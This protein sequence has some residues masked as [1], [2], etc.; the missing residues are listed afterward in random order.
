MSNGDRPSGLIVKSDGKELVIK[1]EFAGEVIVQWAAI[2]EINSTDTLHLLVRD[3]QALAGRVKILPGNV[4]VEAQDKGP[5][6]ISRDSQLLAITIQPDFFATQ[7]G[8]T[9]CLGE[10]IAS[11]IYCRR[12]TVAPTLVLLLPAATARQK[13]WLAFTA[14]RKIRSDHLGM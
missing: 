1:T 6:A 8:R 11:G 5:V 10:I 7:S 4:E 13:I 9:D 3:R 14:D 12:G 2:T